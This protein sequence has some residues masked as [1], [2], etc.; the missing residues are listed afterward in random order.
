MSY[1]DNW[2]DMRA[3]VRLTREIFAQPA[4]DWRSVAASVVDLC[5]RPGRDGDF[6][7]AEPDWGLRIARESSRGS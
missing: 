5:A 7:W 4:L 2:E 3:C 1:A 6:N